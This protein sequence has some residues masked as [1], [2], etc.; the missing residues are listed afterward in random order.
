MELDEPVSYSTSN[1]DLIGNES[2]LVL[3]EAEVQNELAPNQPNAVPNISWAEESEHINQLN[4]LHNQSS[5]TENNP[6][7]PNLSFTSQLST[8][9]PNTQAPSSYQ[10]DNFETERVIHWNSML[11]LGCSNAT[12][13]IDFFISVKADKK[14]TSKRSLTNIMSKIEARDRNFFRSFTNNSLIQPAHQKEY[15]LLTNEYISNYKATYN[16]KF[17]NRAT[18]SKIKCL[19]NKILFIIFIRSSLT[20]DAPYYQIAAWLD[21]GFNWFIDPKREKIK[22]EDI[23]SNCKSLIRDKLPDLPKSLDDISWAVRTSLPFS[24]PITKK[25]TYSRNN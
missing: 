17:V 22:F 1:T 24:F 6:Q 15:D 10:N 7:H 18:K 4:D 14:G 25:K 20:S 23:I 2:S 11:N 8:H 9:I 13:I 21:Y 3:F 16:L 5:N 12:E 19:I